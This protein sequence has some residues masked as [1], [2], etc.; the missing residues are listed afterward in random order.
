MIYFITAR[1]MGMVKIGCADDPQ[2]RFHTVQVSCPFDLRLERV[3]KGGL[4]GEARLHAQFADIRI[5]GEWFTITAEL[6]TLMQSLPEHQWKHRG[7]QH[8]A[9]RLAKA[10]LSSLEE[11][12][13]G[14]SRKRPEQ[15][16]AA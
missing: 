7:W 5:R 12:A 2:A 10:E 14:A 4:S 8:A 16:V 13:S 3:C 9:R 1:E 11:L 15:D 6:E